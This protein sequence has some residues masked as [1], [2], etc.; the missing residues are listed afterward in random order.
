MDALALHECPP[1]IAPLP[2]RP[3][4]RRGQKKPPSARQQAVAMQKL[5]AQDAHELKDPVKRAVVARAWCDLNEEVRKLAMRPLPRPVDTT[6][7]PRRGSRSKAAQIAPQE[8][9]EPK[10]PDSAK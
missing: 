7:L 3:P 2:K 1:E 6:K 9:T 5:L 8:P 4:C 10:T